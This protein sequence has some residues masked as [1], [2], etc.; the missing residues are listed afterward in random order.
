MQII[1]DFFNNYHIDLA[2]PLA[3]A[4]S[5]GADSLAAMLLLKEVFPQLQLIALTVDHQLR[6]TSADEARYVAYIAARYG[7]EH[8]TL[9][10]T[11]KKPTTG[12]EEKARIVRYNLLCNWCK[13]NNIFSLVLAH[14][15]SDQAE[16]F[17]MRLQRGSGIYGLSSMEDV[18]WKNN[19]R[20]LRPFLSFHPDLFKQ[21]LQKKNISWVEDESNHCTDFLR[22]KIRLFLPIMAEAIGIDAAKI[23]TATR[24]LQRT[25]S[26]LEDT[27]TQ[28]IETK[29]HFW[30]KSGCSFDYAEFLS[31]HDELKF[32]IFNR[33][34]ILFGNSDYAPE[35]E[36]LLNLIDDIQQEIFSVHTLSDCLIIKQDLRLWIVKEYREQRLPYSAD[37]W[38]KFIIQNPFVRGIKIPYALRKALL[39]EK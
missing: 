7:I 15:L 24:N 11:E 22:V 34:I 5:G 32:H 29:V 20:L 1:Q 35:A 33:L 31:W 37:M 9:V 17:L 2:K 36:S 6:S 18:S 39:N 3:V 30:Q 8:H 21:Y 38:E 10:W 16:T 14:H 23:F 12:I 26:F 19:I 13:Q 27:V 25:K 28:I 4:V